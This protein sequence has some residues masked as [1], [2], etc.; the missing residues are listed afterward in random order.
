MHAWVLIFWVYGASP[1]FPP[2]VQTQEYTT[3]KECVDTARA[4]RSEFGER[5][6]FVCTERGAAK[7]K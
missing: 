3:R 4:L 5:M 2:A 1:S 7:K 6:G